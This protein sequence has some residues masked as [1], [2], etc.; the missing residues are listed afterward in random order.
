[1]ILA[2]AQ[3]KPK[4]GDIEYNLKDH[5]R[6][7][8]KASDQGTDLIVFPEMSI[9]GYEREDAYKFTFSEND[10]RLDNLRK[11]AH[12]KKIIIVAGAPIIIDLDLFIGSFIL[13]PNGSISIYTKQFLHLG[14]EE[15]FKS[16]FEY[17]PIIEF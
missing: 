7:I 3:T 11:M 15:F 2:S 4:R 13:Y 6:L 14:E 9:T 1:M 8:E 5:Y 16:S 10:S 17:N 12:D